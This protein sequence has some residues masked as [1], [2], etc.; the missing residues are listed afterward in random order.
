MFLVDRSHG[1]HLTVKSNAYAERFVR[2]VKSECLS[3]LIFFSEKGLRR[4]LKEY[5][6]HYHEERNHQGIENVIPFPNERNNPGSSHGN[7]V[8]RERLGGLLRF[9][10]REAA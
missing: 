3:R 10:H 5:M 7:I 1:V 9:Y 6:E 4:A 8:C 2:S